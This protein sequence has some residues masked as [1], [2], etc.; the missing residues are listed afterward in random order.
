MRSNNRIKS[1]MC[2]K[3]T[4]LFSHLFVKQRSLYGERLLC[5]VFASHSLFS[6]SRALRL[7]FCRSRNSTYRKDR[8]KGS[9]VMALK[10][11]QKVCSF[12]Q[13]AIETY[14]RSPKLW[15]HVFQELRDLE[16]DPPTNCSAG[17]L[18]DDPFHWQAKILGPVRATRF[19]G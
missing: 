1:K 14:P 19:E 18:K 8:K 5:F 16:R 9:D 6:R 10:R 7:L 13:R 4:N 11:I 12:A 2:V 15:S 3:R 17:P